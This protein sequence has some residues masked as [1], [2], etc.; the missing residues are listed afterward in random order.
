[1]E[2]I[3]RAPLAQSGPVRQPADL[4]TSPNLLVES[5]GSAAVQTES[6]RTR[7]GRWLDLI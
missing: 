5:D 7:Q 2:Q 6:Q 3:P 1:M 4:A